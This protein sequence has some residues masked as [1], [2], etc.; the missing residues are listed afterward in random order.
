MLE[1]I[2]MFQS[3][4]VIIIYALWTSNK[5]TNAINIIFFLELGTSVI[6]LFFVLLPPPSTENSLSTHFHYFFLPINISFWKFHI[7]LYNQYEPIE[8]LKI[9]QKLF[10]YVLY[11]RT[12]Y[13]L[14][15]DTCFLNNLPP[16]ENK[17]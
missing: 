12:N 1:A 10:S 3:T 9:S 13:F 5:Y 8:K 6:V 14:F 16:G 2:E 7:Q 11:V 17:Q 4:C 15:R